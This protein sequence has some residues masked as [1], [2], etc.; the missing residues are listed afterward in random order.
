[1][2]K[3]AV[4]SMR[5]FTNVH[6]WL[7]A[8]SVLVT[9]VAMAGDA[10]ENKW[11]LS[12]S[13][14]THGPKGS[15]DEVAVKD[16]SIV[17]FEGMW[18][19]FYSARSESEYTTGYVSAKRLADLQSAPRHEL[20]MI[21]GRS[22][23]GCAPQ[24]FCFEPQRK[25]YL[26]FQNGDANYQPAYSTTTTISKPETW[27]K[28]E[29]LLVK[30]DPRKWIDFWVICD[31]TKAYLFYTQAHSAVIVRST[32]LE[33]FPDDWSEENEV[34]KS[35][36]EAVHVYKVSDR[37]VFH[38]IYELNNRG[39]RS[40]GLA[41]AEDIAGPWT[42][43]TD[44]YA[45]G[46]QLNYAGKG[47]AW[48]EMVSHGEVLRADCNERMEYDPKGCTWLI[49]GILKKNS[50]ASYESLPWKLGIMTMLEGS[51][52]EATADVE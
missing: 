49:Q 20:D 3:R 2:R 18:H 31:A 50:R 34:L 27:S 13:I 52:K 7:L 38:M 15:F 1:M 25:W 40:F 22:R 4:I 8:C 6:A 42:K 48:T 28:P 23:Y 30:D 39:I 5:L 11:K 37:N 24:V 29:P 32:T 9:A 33:N 44:N 41:S 43:V 14:L 10:S 35:V 51:D 21:K 45:T 19:V 12:D 16:P 36:H 17:F 46:D 47:E 26:I